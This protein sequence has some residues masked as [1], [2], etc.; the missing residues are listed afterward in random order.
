MKQTPTTRTKLAQILGLGLLSSF[1]TLALASTPFSTAIPPGPEVNQIEF[2]LG[3]QSKDGTRPGRY[4]GQDEKGAYGRL[5]LELNLKDPNHHSYSQVIARDLGGDAQYFRA[6]NGQQGNFAVGIEYNQRTLSEYQGLPASF[7]NNQLQLPAPNQSPTTNWN[8]KREREQLR[9]MAQKIIN[10]EWRANLVLNREDKTGNKLQGFGDWNGYVGFQ[11]PAPIHQRTDQVGATVEYAGK[12]L[13]GRFGVNISQFKQLEDNFFTAENPASGVAG[14]SFNLNR[15]PENTYYQLNG[16]LAYQLSNATRFSFE[17]DY[18]EAKQDDEFIY[19]NALNQG[20]NIYDQITSA[21]GTSLNAKV[22]TTRLAARATHRY[23]ANTLVRAN[24]RYDDRST[25]KNGE[26]LT[27]ATEK[28]NTGIGANQGIRG[29]RSHDYTR[30]T[31]DIDATTRVLG[32]STLLAGI[33]LDYTERDKDLADRKETTDINLHGRLRSRFGNNLTTGLK[34]VYVMRTGTTYD[35]TITS[36]NESLRKYHL[37]DV[38]RINIVANA[39]YSLSDSLALGLE[40]T[41]KNDDYKK[42]AVGLTEDERL[43]ATLTADYFPSNRLSGY[44]F[45]TYEDGSRSQAGV[46]VGSRA[47]KLDLDLDTLTLG[48]GGNYQLTADGKWKLGA[49]LLVVNNTS[50]LKHTTGNNS[51]LKA[52]LLETKLY[53]DWQAQ[54]NLNI[55]L[56]YLMHKY[57]ETN[58][59]GIDP[60]KYALMSS[61]D[62][63][64]TVHLVMATA[65][66]K[67]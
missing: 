29:I 14:N 8:I 37:A 1:G 9:L 34:A 11:M 44:T 2:T 4:L 32:S 50:K 6:R 21:L 36:N 40:V 67:F 48:L 3:Y 12:Q 60:D 63:D 46:D 16:T 23:N 19:D 24:Y 52:D 57:E 30:H 54:E 43:A 17:A 13:Q 51:K 5:N 25:S 53:A 22:K 33:K 56:A 61:G 42:S 64:Q 41:Y 62:Y 28:T 18:A 65:Q 66:F 59:T 20:N 38:D 7:T 26:G 15:A 49:D 31:A 35:D 39:N 58:L 27:F 10:N 45:I 55:K 47:T